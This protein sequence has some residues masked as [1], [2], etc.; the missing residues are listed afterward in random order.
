M[1]IL[2]GIFKQKLYKNNEDNDKTLVSFWTS[3]RTIDIDA[4][5]VTNKETTLENATTWDSTYDDVDTQP[6]GLTDLV[7]KITAFFKNT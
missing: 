6:T 2:S 4:D 1:S 3:T 7:S 5:N